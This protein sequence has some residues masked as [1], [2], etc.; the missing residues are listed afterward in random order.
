MTGFLNALYFSA[1]ILWGTES[2]LT[3]RE[4]YKHDPE[5]DTTI[6][7]KDIKQSASSS[8]GAFNGSSHPAWFTHAPPAALYFSADDGVN[9]RE[10]WSVR[11]TFGRLHVLLYPKW[12]PE[13]IVNPW[14]WQAEL[15]TEDIEVD[16]AM[17]TFLL[18]RDGR[19]RFFDRVDVDLPRG[20]EQERTA[21]L[22]TG[23]GMGTESG[24]ATLA[25]AVFDRQTGA[26]IGIE[27]ASVGIDERIGQ[28]EQVEIQQRAASILEPLSLEAIA[29]L[30]HGAILSTSG[31]AAPRR[32]DARE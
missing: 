5:K 14:E 23:H 7:L 31:R 18:M 3:G 26:L 13:E 9:G 28:K 30:D 25:V 27:T 32:V 17:G 15:K 1:D 4:L 10:L 22:V 6:L 24:I 16:V 19:A 20:Q 11:R 12:T 2:V 21:L 29:E 8:A